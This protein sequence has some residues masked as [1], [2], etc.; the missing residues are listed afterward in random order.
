[1]ANMWRCWTVPRLGGPGSGRLA[2]ARLKAAVGLVNNV[3]PALA[4]HDAVVAVAAAQGF[5]RITDFHDDLWVL[6]WPGS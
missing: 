5:E 1:M 2:L 6:W 3:D 4:P